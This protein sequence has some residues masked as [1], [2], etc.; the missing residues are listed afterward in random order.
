MKKVLLTG[1]TGF[2]G[3]QLL[4]HLLMKQYSL[5]VLLRDA[6]ASILNDNHVDIFTGDLTQPASLINVCENIDTVF[7][8]AA[9]A[10]D[11]GRNDSELAHKHHAINYLGT[12]HILA[13]AVRSKVK[14]FLYV[15]SVKAV[16]DDESCI[17]ENWDQQPNTP[18]GIA[19]RQ[20][21]NL[22]LSVGKENN[23]HVSILRPP[24]VYGPNLKGNLAAMLKA[25]DKGY[26]P[27]LPDTHNKRSLVS[28]Y[29]IC[30]AAL[31]AAYH[32]KANG[33]I[34]FVTDG[35]DYSTR[36]LYDL[37]CQALGKSPYA[38]YVPINIF[39][40]LAFAGTAMEKLLGKQMPIN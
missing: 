38:W 40:L 16:A 20:A 25:I 34:Y 19:K 27:P 21:E 36:R 3:K 26:F 1:A 2:I 37:M 29:D 11:T 35:V 22:V 6:N 15:S 9:Y 39:K 17:D 28:V 23:M 4:N 8:L 32:P 33:K 18:Y 13:E 31:L 14:H 7:H 12:K 30:E 10:H 5:R 24:L